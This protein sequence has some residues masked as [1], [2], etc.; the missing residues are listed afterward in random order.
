MHA[1][2]SHDLRPSRSKSGLSPLFVGCG[3]KVERKHTGEGGMDPSLDSGLNPIAQ[4]VTTLAKSH[5][6]S[7]EVCEYKRL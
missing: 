5:H 4:A 2:V 7:V 1:L 6:H 3:E